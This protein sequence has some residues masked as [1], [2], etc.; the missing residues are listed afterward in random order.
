LLWEFLEQWR[1][2]AAG[3]L[4]GKTPSVLAF[5]K[6]IVVPEKQKMPYKLKSRVLY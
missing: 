2:N 6:P 3:Y 5:H 4:P 1:Q